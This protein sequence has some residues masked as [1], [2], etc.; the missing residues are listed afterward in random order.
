[1]TEKMNKEDLDRLVKEELNK[2]KGKEEKESFIER[3]KK[4][5]TSDT[6]KEFY[7]TMALGMVQGIIASW[8]FDTINEF[9][10][11]DETVI[12]IEE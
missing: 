1:M 4:T 2:M 12:E 3:A 10:T 8:T 6:A 11:N 7:K 9:Q 5:L